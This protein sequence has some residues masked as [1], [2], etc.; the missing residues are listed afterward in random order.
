MIKH[1][2]TNF[3]ESEVNAAIAIIKSGMIAQGEKVRQLEKSL[4]AAIER[5]YCAALSSG[6]IAL[7]L[8]L[9]ALGIEPND[10]VI[11]PSYTCTALYHAVR[12]NNATPVY[13]D[14][15]EETCN[16][17]PDSVKD[18]LSPKTKAIIFPH[19]FGQPGYIKEIKKLGIPVIEDIA[20]SVG[21]K[22][23][24]RM[25]GYYGDIAVISFYAT[26]MLGAGEGGAILTD[27]KEYYDYITEHRAYDEMDQLTRRYNAKMTNIT[28]GIALA[29][30]SKLSSFI[31]K[32]EEIK[33]FYR[34]K[35]KFP[36]DIPNSGKEFYPNYYRYIITCNDAEKLIALGIKKGVQFRKPVFKP[37]HLYEKNDY[38]PVT[39]K[40]WHEQ[41][42]IP[43]YPQLTKK[44]VNTIINV[45][46]H[47]EDIHE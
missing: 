11:I 43:I 35:L 12:F 10:E 17:A 27:T 9:E 20:Q 32:R 39:E 16:L 14:I 26:K 25:T 44:E 42:S 30:L 1:N 15:E 5:Q 23:D 2:Q 18:K 31:S 6:T 8:A 45:C 41:V 21:A 37:I 3:D 19:M 24:N 40:K 22:I 4:S 33:N 38:L 34:D 47:Y 28:A 13:A 36:V 29:Q 7:S 46:N